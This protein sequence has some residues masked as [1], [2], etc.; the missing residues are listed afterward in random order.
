MNAIE[1]A[2]L[3]RSP[4]ERLVIA[5]LGAFVL[6]VVVAV[7]AWLPLERARHRTAAQLPALRASLAALERDALEV[8]R[9]RAM[10]AAT[11]SAVAAPQPLASLATNAGGLAGARITVLDERRVRVAGDDLAFG[12]LLEW[13]RNAQVTHRMRV[14]TAHLEALATAGRVK[15]ELVLEKD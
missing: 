3:Q 2:W 8:K 6:L 4:R 1:R 12:S 13:L 15:A 11:A 14:S 7:F 10:P 9:L 5:A